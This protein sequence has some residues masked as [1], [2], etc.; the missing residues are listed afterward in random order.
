MI[1]PHKYGFVGDIF[2]EPKIIEEY[3]LIDRQM[4]KGRAMLSFN[5]NKNEWGWKAIEIK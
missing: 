5:K 2:I 3:K 4:V 1:Y